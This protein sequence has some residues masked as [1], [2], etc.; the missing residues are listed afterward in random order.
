MTGRRS[1]GSQINKPNGLSGQVVE[2]NGHTTIRTHGKGHHKEAIID[3]YLANLDDSLASA[4][5]ADR[6]PVTAQRQA[7]I[8]AIP[9]AGFPRAEFAPASTELHAD[10]EAATVYGQTVGK[11]VAAQNE[12]YTTLQKHVA[13]FDGDGDGVIWPLDTYRGF[14]ACGYGYII[15]F[16]AIFIIHSAFSYPTVSGYLPDPYF[17]VYIENIHRC[18]HGS[19]SG[20]YD[21]EGRFVPQKAHDFFHKYGKGDE[22]TSGELYRATKGQRVLMDP[23]GVFAA[24]FEWWTTWLIAVGSTTKGKL[25]RDDARGVIDGSLFYKLKEE[26]LSR[27]QT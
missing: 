21:N 14:R 5:V 22:L 17:R 19:D 9:H 25:S 24:I 18:K 10:A 23:F 1:S 2:V 27:E 26:R 3:E 8:T 7:G 11:Q 13:F 20:A 15:S 4:S 12:G 16:L 6:A